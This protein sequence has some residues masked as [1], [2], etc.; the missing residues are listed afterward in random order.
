MLSITATVPAA[1]LDD[2]DLLIRH[3]EQIQT[4]ETTVVEIKEHNKWTMRLLIS[5]L[6]AAVSTLLAAVGG[7]LAQILKH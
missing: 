5:T 1:P 6:I 4:L 3:D 7:L 2:H